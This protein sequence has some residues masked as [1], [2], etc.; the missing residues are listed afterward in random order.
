MSR[1]G[2][3]V[4]AGGVFHVISRFVAKQWLMKSVAERNMYMTEVGLAI[5]DTDWRCFAFALMS[6]HTHLAFVAGSDA[7]VSWMRPA[8]NHFANWLNLRLE[9][10]G[11][12][13]VRG[14]NV[15]GVQPEGVAKLISYIHGNPVRAGVVSRA[16][17]SDWT[18]HRAYIGS[19]PRPPWLD[20][21]LGLQLAG[22][23]DG[24][25]FGAWSD[26]THVRREDV[27]EFRIR[28][29]RG[30]PRKDVGMTDAEEL[31]LFE[32]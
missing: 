12:V 32:E 11:A 22:F 20:V 31:Q 6:S 16:E 24:A 4:Q 15:I 28:G 18:S 17:Q 10:I 25:S 13:F 8:H 21:S 3:S 30:R 27:D 7:L 9:R 1:G 14:P 5:R 2:G 29:R 19:G 23:P 26:S